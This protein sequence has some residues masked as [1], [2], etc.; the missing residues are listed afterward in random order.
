MS[1]LLF[2]QREPCASCPY[3]TDAPPEL[4]SQEEF[5]KLLRNDRT[6]MGTLY[7]CHEYRKRR[8][9]AQVCVG[10]LLDQRARNVPSM[11]LRLTL[12]TNEQARACYNEAKS[13]VPLFP[14][15]EQM[16]EANGVEW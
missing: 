14:S 2:D 3:R 11:M 4:W 8:H 10:W 15:I 12:M 7:G 6:E 1:K 5:L 9:E 13:P 16:C